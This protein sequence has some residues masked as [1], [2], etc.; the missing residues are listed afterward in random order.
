[1]APP[2]AVFLRS[3]VVFVSGQSEGRLEGRWISG[4]T[5]EVHGAIALPLDADRT[6]A[7]GLSGTVGEALGVRF[8]LALE[9]G[10]A[11]DG[12]L[13][14][15]LEWS[16]RY[17]REWKP[18]SGQVWRLHV[19]AGGQGRSRGGLVGVVAAFETRGRGR[20]RWGCAQA[21][22]HPEAPAR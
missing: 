10:T 11:L 9:D 18:A 1:M 20:W 12:Q 8:G 14:E 17:R 6:L 19:G 2:G 3:G 21:W 22:G 7:L 5:G 4:G 16:A 13:A 15:T